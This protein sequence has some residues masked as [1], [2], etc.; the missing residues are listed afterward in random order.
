MVLWSLV[1]SPTYQM[2]FKDDLN[3]DGTT[4]SECQADPT[5]AGVVEHHAT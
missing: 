1:G 5:I 4:S 3:G 2:F